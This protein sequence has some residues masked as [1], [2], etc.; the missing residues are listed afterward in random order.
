M[1]SGVLLIMSFDCYV[2]ICNAPRYAI[3]LTDTRVVCMGLPVII[4]SFCMVCPLPF[5]LKRLPFCN[6][7]M[8]SRAVHA[9]QIF[10]ASVPWDPVN[11]EDTSFPED[12]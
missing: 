11:K 5:L 1:E 9:T 7:N 2:A 12:L 10:L 6:A 8:W 4:R 3:V